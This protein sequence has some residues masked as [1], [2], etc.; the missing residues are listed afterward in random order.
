MFN[1]ISDTLDVAKLDQEITWTEVWENELSTEIDKCPKCSDNIGIYKLSDGT[2]IRVHYSDSMLTELLQEKFTLCSKEGD[3]LCEIWFENR[4]IPAQWFMSNEDKKAF[5]VGDGFWILKSAMS[6]LATRFTDSLPLHASAIMHDSIGG[7]CFVW[8]HRAWKTTGLLNV[9]YIL[10]WWTIVS[11]DWIKC[12]QDATDRLLSTTDASISLSEKTIQENWHL[13][14]MHNSEV[15]TQVKRR[16]T[17]YKPSSLLWENYATGDTT[18]NHLVLLAE[19]LDSAIVRLPQSVPLNVIA[20]FMVGATYHYPYSSEEL[21]DDHIKLWEEKL[22]N[23]QDSI[24]I[25]NRSKTNWL[26]S[27][28]RLLIDFLLKCKK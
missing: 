7:I 22:S 18:M 25:F 2:R 21:R 9:A 13:P 24:Y 15:L 8:W 16:K 3:Y 5:I 20:K 4:N 6:W 17:S 10:W 11:D 14:V 19:G 27:G 12:T 23:F 1:A 26:E 28:Y